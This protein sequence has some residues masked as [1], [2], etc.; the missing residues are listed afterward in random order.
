MLLPCHKD[1]T[2]VETDIIIWNIGISSKC[3]FQNILSDRDPKL[4]SALW[5]N[6]H[7][8]FGTKLPISKAYKPQTDGLAEIMMQTLEY[9][10][11]RF[12]AYGLKFKKSDGFTHD[13][14]TL[15]PAL[16]LAYKTLIE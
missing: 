5:K 4:T 9:M 2:A 3:F 8:L 11:R 10:I 7:N 6:I 13:L 14:C 16:E 15:I 1:D 12:C